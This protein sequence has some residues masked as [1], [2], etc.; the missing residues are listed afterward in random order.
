[1]K[2]LK[3]QALIFVTAFNHYAPETTVQKHPEY[4]TLKL[5]YALSSPIFRHSQFKRAPSVISYFK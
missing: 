5:S 4:V 3:F 1:M 2:A